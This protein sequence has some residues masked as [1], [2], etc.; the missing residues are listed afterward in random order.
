MKIGING[1]LG[2]QLFQL[3]FAHFNQHE[4][5]DLYLD[6]NPRDDRPYELAIL[7]KNCRHVRKINKNNTF[8]FKVKI[9]ISRFP[10]KFHLLFLKKF[11]VRLT[12]IIIESH[13]YMFNSLE[14]LNSNNLFLGYFQHWKFV[15]R[16][17]EYFGI[18]L[19]ETLAQIDVLKKMNFNPEN[20]IILHIRQ[21]DLVNVKSSM[22]VLGHEYYLRGIHEI[23]SKFPSISFRYIAMTDDVTRAKELSNY[24]SISEIYGPNDLTA[25]ETLK[26]MS[27]CKFLICANSTLSWWGAFINSKNR[28]ISVMPDP[29]FRNWHE[30]VGDAFFFPETIPVK[31]SFF[32]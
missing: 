21:G 27:I 29:W 14:I 6:G 23:E 20:T 12:R 2:N 28:G 19:L 9:K 7:A 26:I 10:R 4:L 11:F 32:E 24:I 17:W 16:N 25:W 3:S 5:I 31:S 22:G 15:E 13:P 30:T 8:S 18:E 1:G